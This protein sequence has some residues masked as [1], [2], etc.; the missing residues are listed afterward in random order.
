[1]AQALDAVIERA[2]AH[3]DA[4][5]KWEVAVGAGVPAF[6]AERGFVA[7]RRPWAAVGTEGVDGYVLWLTAADH[8]EPGYYAQTTLFT[9]GAVAALIA[10]EGSGPGGF[11]GG[12][13]DRD[14]EIAFWRSASNYPACEPIG[15]AVAL[16]DRLADAPVEVA[17]DLE[18]PALLEGLEGFDRSFRA[19]L[20]DDSLRQA[21]ARGIPVR[22]DRVEVAEIARRVARGERA[23]LLIDEAPMHGEVGP[24]WI[25]A[26]A[27]AGDAV[28]VEDPWINVEAG[29]TWV[30]THELPI[31]PAD[32]DLLVRW[33]DD[34]YRGV[35][36]ARVA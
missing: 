14:R 7:M 29:E 13:G 25:V 6:A 12:A 3:G 16:H 15:L 30:D 10:S 22:R 19:E 18:G 35:I 2:R 5:L 8:D 33:S 1:A 21:I 34:A 4:A 26:H 24:H 28:V 31:Q 11:D 23:L 20:Q 9:C 17:L 32:L 27:V 36:F